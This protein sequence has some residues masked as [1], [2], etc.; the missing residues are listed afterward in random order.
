MKQ[1]GELIEVGLVARHRFMALVVCAI[2]AAITLV[3]IALSL[4]NSSG[5]AQLDLSRPG[6]AGVRSQAISS[7]T[8]DGFPSIGPLDESALNQFRQLYDARMKD[9]QA[10]DAF[11][12]NSL[13]DVTLGIDAPPAT[14]PQP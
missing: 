12:G 13:D 14:P 1:D 5:A 11:G 9:V 6:Y 3:T 8:Y 2:M 7:N 4:Y 10:V